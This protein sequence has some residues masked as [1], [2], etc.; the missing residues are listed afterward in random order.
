M[1]EMLAESGGAAA[2]EKGFNDYAALGGMLDGGF[3]QQVEFDLDSFQRASGRLFNRAEQ[4]RF[5]TIQLQAIRWTFL[6][7]GMTHPNFLE[8]V[9]DLNPAARGQIEEMAPAFC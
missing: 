3:R 4:D 8:T 6:G 2:I 7:S 5:R 9:G 1:I